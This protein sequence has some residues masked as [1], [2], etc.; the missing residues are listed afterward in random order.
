M[1]NTPYCCNLQNIVIAL[2]SKKCAL[3]YTIVLIPKTSRSMALLKF[4]PCT[5]II[6]CKQVDYLTSK[7]K[8]KFANCK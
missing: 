3:S 7:K 1:F 2:L 4:W 5:I 8:N 6:L